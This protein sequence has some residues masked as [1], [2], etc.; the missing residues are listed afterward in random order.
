MK[1]SQNVKFSINIATFTQ[2]LGNIFKPLL[3]NSNG[4]KDLLHSDCRSIRSIILRL[5]KKL[6]HYSHLYLETNQDTSL[7][8]YLYLM[9]ILQ[10]SKIFWD[11]A[12]MKLFGIKQQ[13]ERTAHSSKFK[14]HQKAMWKISFDIFVR[15]YVRFLIFGYFYEIKFIKSIQQS[16][17]KKENNN[18]GIWLILRKS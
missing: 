18:F 17:F 1:C 15:I 7:L 6:A 16:L 9:I 8:V 11:P 13:A 14:L 10:D 4:S 5:L 12:T 3:L 2:C